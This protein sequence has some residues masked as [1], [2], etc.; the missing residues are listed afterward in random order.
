LSKKNLPKDLNDDF[1]ENKSL[2]QKGF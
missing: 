1:K 2:K